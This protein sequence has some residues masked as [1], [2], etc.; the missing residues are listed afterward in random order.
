MKNKI[1]VFIAMSCAGMLQA[2]SF[3]F[4]PTP[5]D[6]GDLDHQSAYIWGITNSTLKWDL[7]N[8]YHL[9]GATLTINNLYN[10]DSRDTGNKLFINLLD[11][12]ALGVASVIDDPTDN[13]INQGFRSDYFDGKLTNN[14]VNGKWVAYGYTNDSAGNQTTGAN[15][16]A[17]IDLTDW[18]DPD[19]PTTKTNFSY[20]FT[21]GQLGTLGGYITDGHTGTGS[22]DFGLGFDPDCHF[23]NSGICLTVTVEKDVRVPDAGATFGLL[24]LAMA[25]LVGLRR[26]FKLA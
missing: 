19:G 8:G 23:Y 1:I 10:W 24:G 15:S 3:N 2:D 17:K 5:T 7:S 18:S 13:G 20:A 14:K 9:T 25:G 22:A 12:P 4:S 26:K 6:L 21:V 11:N 16:G